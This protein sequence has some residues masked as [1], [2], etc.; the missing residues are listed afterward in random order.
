[1]PTNCSKAAFLRVLEFLHL[2]DLAVYIALLVELCQL[3]DFY[4]LEG[5]K[6]YCKGVCMKRMYLRYYNKLMT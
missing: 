5:L 2:D 3:I 1:M 4:Q 6:H